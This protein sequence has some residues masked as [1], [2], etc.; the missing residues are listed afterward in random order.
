MKPRLSIWNNLD[1][2]AAWK[3][4]DLQVDKKFSTCANTFTKRLSIFFASANP[5]IFNI[6]ELTLPSMHPTSAPDIVGRR[7]FLNCKLDDTSTF[8]SE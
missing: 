5:Q 1:T 8:P 7:S 3:D 6:S 2:A 4:D